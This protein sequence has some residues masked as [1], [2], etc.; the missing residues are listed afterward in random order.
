MAEGEGETEGGGG[1]EGMSQLLINALSGKQKLSDA[2][3]RALIEYL[4]QNLSEEQVAALQEKID[5]LSE[6]KASGGVGGGGPGGLTDDTLA[7]AFKD[8]QRILGGGGGGST[9]KTTATKSTTA[10]TGTETTEIN[11][12]VRKYIDV[13]TP[14]EV[15]DDFQTGFAT[16]MRQVAGPGGVSRL[17]AAW[18]IDNMEFF[19][20]DY[21]GVLGEAASRG[22]DIFEVVG[23]TGKPQFLGSRE[24]DIMSQTSKIKGTTTQKGAT[25]GTVT[26]T[27]AGGTEVGGFTATEDETVS[28]DMLENLSINETEDVFRR[29][30]LAYVRKYSPLEHMQAKW[31]PASIMLRYEGFKGARAAQSRGGEAVSARRVV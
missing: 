15:L 7:E 14:E 31:S 20:T 25:T 27:G 12:R 29:P 10:I 19:M 1:P 13:P 6:E 23:A 24:G 2:Q 4:E 18:S 8:L 11:R 28:K 21:L 9:S 16:H 5:A 17:A 26:E 22:E 3:Q 30:K